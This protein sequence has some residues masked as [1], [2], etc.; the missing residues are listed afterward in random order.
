M[1]YLLRPNQ[2]QKQRLEQALEDIVHLLPSTDVLCAIAFGSL[3]TGDVGAASD[4]DLLV[5]RPTPLRFLD[6]AA[7][8]YELFQV[9]V[10]L[11]LL[12]YT[13]E[14]FERMKIDNPLIRHAVRTGRVVYEAKPRA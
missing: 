6:R 8:L 7:D 5:V 11:D 2:E 10:G 13:P 9:P 12:V 3:V 1:S 14:E 4:L